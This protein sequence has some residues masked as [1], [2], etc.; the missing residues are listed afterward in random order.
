[1]LR[2]GL[3]CARASLSTDSREPERD[4]GSEM[5]GDGGSGSEMDRG[6]VALTSAAAA[7]TSAAAAATSA[8]A[9]AAAS[10]AASAAAT[11]SAAARLLAAA[12][13]V[14]TKGGGGGK[15][16]RCSGFAGRE[17]WPRSA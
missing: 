9:G 14:R 1:M 4:L 15:D 13:A 3:G 5:V 2:L 12:V 6:S 16:A 10:A 7:A 17:D 11:T 8:A